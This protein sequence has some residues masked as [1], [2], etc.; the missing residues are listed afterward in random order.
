MKNELP[1]TIKEIKLLKWKALIRTNRT[2]LMFSSE[3]K[4]EKKRR[5]RKALIEII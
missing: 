5:K 2:L 1:I 3:L 4:Q